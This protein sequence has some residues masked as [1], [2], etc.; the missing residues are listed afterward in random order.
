MRD[1]RRERARRR[2]RGL[3]GYKRRKAKMA[4]DAAK[5]TKE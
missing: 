5:R 1:S 2:H 4:N 3:T